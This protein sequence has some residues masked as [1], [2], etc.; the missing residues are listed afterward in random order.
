ML[1]KT[2]AYTSAL[3]DAISRRR[4]TIGRAVAIPVTNIK[5]KKCLTFRICTVLKTAP[6]ATVSH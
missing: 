1:S 5:Q 4:P 2:F 3:T 6:R